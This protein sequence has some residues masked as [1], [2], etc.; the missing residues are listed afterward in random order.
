[1][2]FCQ[3]RPKK[4]RNLTLRIVRAPNCLMAYHSLNSID[5]TRVFFF[6]LS[7][8]SLL[9]A[10]VRLGTLRGGLQLGEQLILRAWKDLNGV[11][12]TTRGK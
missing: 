8:P 7:S 9:L 6:E 12:Q 3:L 5:P 4:V 10:A 1:M 11:P 2:I